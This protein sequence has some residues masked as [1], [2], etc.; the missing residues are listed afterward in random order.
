MNLKMQTDYALRTL[1]Y[2]AHRGEQAPVEEIAKAYAISKEHLFKVVQHLVRFGYV[3]SR[4]G[5][6]G[7][8][9]L[10]KDPAT[11]NV[12]EVIERFE[13]RNGLLPCVNDPHDCVLEPGCYLRHLLID[14][15]QA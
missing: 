6:N 9:R 4:T 1:L 5:R 13:G 7:G 12:G 11:V 3:Q 2:L 15:E 8:V 10:V 14:A